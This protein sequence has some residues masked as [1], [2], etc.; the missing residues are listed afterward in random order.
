MLLIFYIVVLY[1]ISFEK[2]DRWLKTFLKTAELK[3]LEDHSQVLQV[4]VPTI[5]SNFIVTCW[6]SVI[7]SEMY[8]MCFVS[9]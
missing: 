9:L 5:D 2:D 4:I 8:K 6:V 1:K 3:A 7:Y